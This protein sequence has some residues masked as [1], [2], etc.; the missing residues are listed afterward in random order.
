MNI[1]FYYDDHVDHPSVKRDIG[2]YYLNE[3]GVLMNYW[4]WIDI[5]GGV[6]GGNSD[7]VISNEIIKS[8]TSGDKSGYHRDCEISKEQ[9]ERITTRLLL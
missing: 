5:N 6:D 4:I 9:Y 3:D 2:Y 8:I 7:V 1:L